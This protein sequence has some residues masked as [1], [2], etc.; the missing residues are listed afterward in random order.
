LKYRLECWIEA[1]GCATEGRARELSEVRR[2][3]QITEAQMLLHEVVSSFLNGGEPCLKAL[4]P[5]KDV[6]SLPL[7]PVYGTS[8][9]RE[10]LTQEDLARWCLAQIQNDCMTSMVLLEQAGWFPTY[11][12]GEVQLLLLQSEAVSDPSHWMFALEKTF[13]RQNLSTETIARNVL[14]KF[15]DPIIFPLSFLIRILEA[16]FYK[17]NPRGSPKAVEILRS[18]VDLGVIFSSYVDIFDGKYTTNQRTEFDAAHVSRE[19]LLYSLA[20]VTQSLF[21]VHAHHR[22]AHWQNLD[23][24]VETVKVKLETLQRSSLRQDE[25]A[26]HALELVKR[27]IGPLKEFLDHNYFHNR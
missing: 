22:S 2:W 3:Y 17:E 8:Y 1:V 18:R 9:N 4:L 19:Y 24:A 15:Y 21:E 11:G 10:R 7:N 5:S 14:N 12:G 16:R 23:S 13:Q 25:N 20:C 27:T 6:Q 26:I